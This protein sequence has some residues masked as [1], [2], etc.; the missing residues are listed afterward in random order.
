AA[1]RGDAQ[2]RVAGILDTGG[3]EEESIYLPLHAVQ[4][5][6]DR[7]HQV[8]LV[9]VSALIKPGFPPAPD[10]SRDPKAFER[11]SCTPCGTPV[12]YALTRGRRGVE[13]RPG[14]QM[15]EA[16]GELV[17]RLN[18]LMLLLTLAA[19]VGAALGVM[20]TMTASVV[21]RTPEIALARAIGATRGSI[22]RFLVSEALVLALA[23]GLIG[24]RLGSGPAPDAGGAAVRGSVPVP[25]P[26]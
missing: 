6:L 7:S 17:L 19:L 3:M 25:P 14:R 24:G 5:W 13:P 8:D 10:A 16:E 22:L 23:G 12:A 18:L 4:D 1:I 9:L 26:A 2:A 11:W 20:S 15:V 21:E